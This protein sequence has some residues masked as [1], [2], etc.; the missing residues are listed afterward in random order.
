VTSAC[1]SPLQKKIKS[2][3]ARADRGQFKPCRIFLERP[4]HKDF[5][6]AIGMTLDR[7]LPLESV[8]NV[9]LDA[10]PALRATAEVLERIAVLAARAGIDVSKMPPL[11]DVT[12]VAK[13]EKAA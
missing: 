2:T 6:R 12:P 1:S 9:K 8:V 4:G 5:G 10:T 13:S 7:N 11:I 3:C